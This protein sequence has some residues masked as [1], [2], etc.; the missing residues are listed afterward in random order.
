M[1]LRVL[2]TKERAI[3]IKGGKKKQAAFLQE[4]EFINIQPHIICLN[5]QLASEVQL[6]QEAQTK[7]KC[8]Q[9]DFIA[10]K[11]WLR[12]HY[13]PLSDLWNELFDLTYSH[14]FPLFLQTA[15]SNH[16]N[17]WGNY[18]CHLVSPS[19]DNKQRQPEQKKT[20]AEKQSKSMGESMIAVLLFSKKPIRR[21]ITMTW[22]S[23]VFSSLT[24][25]TSNHFGRS[26]Q[27]R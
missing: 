22:P 17:S 26:C 25:F 13:M 2:S 14:Q 21:S 10:V 23:L 20:E 19:L 24:V 16:F 11:I 27:K 3:S 18:T 8:T 12:F 7:T 5:D 15:F 6:V 9:R 1:E 4:L